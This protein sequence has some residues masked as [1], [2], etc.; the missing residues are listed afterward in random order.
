MTCSAEPKPC[1]S[2]PSQAKVRAQPRKSLVGTKKYSLASNTALK[3]L[4]QTK[5]R[6]KGAFL[7][8]ADK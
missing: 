8:C 2:Q 5:S 7:S 4:Q 3:V 6:E 1:T